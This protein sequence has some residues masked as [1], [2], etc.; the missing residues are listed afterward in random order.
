MDELFELIGRAL[1]DSSTMLRLKV[2]VA[3]GVG[4]L[5]AGALF[6]TSG[7]DGAIVWGAAMAACGLALIW[8]PVRSFRREAREREA[9]RISSTHGLTPGPAAAA[10]NPSRRGA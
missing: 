4:G 3:G 7:L 5:G 6:M 9:E 10:A 1:P 2:L 8:I